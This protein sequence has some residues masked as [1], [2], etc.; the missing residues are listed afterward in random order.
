MSQFTAAEKEAMKEESR[1][2]S[3][4]LYT[5]HYDPMIVYKSVIVA[6][7]EYHGST[8]VLLGLTLRFS[9]QVRGHSSHRAEIRT[10]AARAPMSMRPR[11]KDPP[12]R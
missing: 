12:K 6:G 7:P 3:P 11:N 10:D 2:S 1:K 5:R 8:K 9:P 4:L